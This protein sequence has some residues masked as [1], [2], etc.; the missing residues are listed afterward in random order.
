ML[1]GSPTCGPWSISNT[2]M[3]ELDLA[4][5]RGRQVRQ[6]EFWREMA[7]AQA[8][9]GLDH[10]LEQPDG[11]HMLRDKP[12]RGI[13]SPI[14]HVDSLPNLVPDQRWCMC[15]HGL[16]DQVSGLPNMKPSRARGSVVLSKVVQWCR[17]PVSA[18][19][20]RHQMLQDAYKAG[21]HRG[22]KRSSVAQEYSKLFCK[23]LSMDIL[24]HLDARGAFRSDANASSF[25]ACEG[26]GDDD[27]AG[28]KQGETTSTTFTTTTKGYEAFPASAGDAPMT[29]D[30]PPL[31]PL[32]AAPTPRLRPSFRRLPF[33]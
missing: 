9:D 25:F 5:L 27:A 28:V 18:D 7:H 32:T 24:S 22:V 21:A 31:V 29:P 16:R 30:L 8:A 11:S 1:F 14:S 17:C 10:M 12:S 19:G 20:R 2:Q 15:A 13:T 6:L 23:R 3:P 26:T 33:V 4:E